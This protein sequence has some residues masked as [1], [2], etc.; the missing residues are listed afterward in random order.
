MSVYGGQAAFALSLDAFGTP[1]S[2]RSAGGVYYLGVGSLQLKLNHA[3]EAAFIAALDEN[4]PAFIGD[5]VQKLLALDIAGLTGGGSA[6]LSV[7][8]I[9]SGLGVTDDGRITLALDTGAALIEIGFPYPSGGVLAGAAVTVRTGD[10]AL[11]EVTLD[12]PVLSDCTS[13]TAESGAPLYAPADADAYVDI[14]EF[15]A[16]LS[17]IRATVTASGF[18]LTLTEDLVLTVPGTTYLVSDDMAA[19]SSTP[20]YDEY[21]EP[22]TAPVTRTVTI[23]A[24]S[25]ATPGVIRI[26]PQGEIGKSGWFVS[27]FADLTVTRTEEV[28]GVDRIIQ[29]RT[30][31]QRISAAL[32]DEAGVKVIYADYDGM[33][34]R[35]RFDEALGTLAYVRDILGITGTILDDIPEDCYDAS[36]D[37]SVFDDMSVAGLESLRAT[38]TDLL[39]RAEAVFNV[40]FGY[41][42]DESAGL[43]GYTGA[44]EALGSITQAADLNELMD[45]V[46]A[47]TDALAENGL[48]SDAA[49]GD[50]IAT[51]Q[52]V[53][54]TIGS[55]QLSFA[56]DTLSVALPADTG[57]ADIALSHADGYLSALSV[58]GLSAGGVT[59]NGALALSTQNV[60][61]TPPDNA[62]TFD[63]TD[64]TEE[65][66]YYSDFSSINSLFEDLINTANLKS[67]F[68]G[69]ENN[70]EK[71]T[72]RMSLPNMG[73][74]VNVDISF[75]VKVV[76]LQNEN[77][78]W[79]PLVHVQLEVPGIW[80]IVT[81]TKARNTSLYFYDDHFLFTSTRTEGVFNKRTY[82]E[83][84]HATTEDLLKKTSAGTLDINNLMKYVY[85]MLPLGSTIQDAVNKAIEKGITQDFSSTN[86]ILNYYGYRNGNYQLGIDLKEIT[87]IQDVNELNVS[88]NTK[89]YQ[90]KNYLNNVQLD[91][92]FLNGAFYAIK[93][94]LNGFM[95][96]PEIT[97]NPQHPQYAAVRQYTYN[98]Y[99]DGKSHT[100]DISTL[101]AMVMSQ[102]AALGNAGTIDSPAEKQIK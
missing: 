28:I 15:S 25:D 67:F 84:V 93:M 30:L 71:G 97:T 88:L 78:E 31:T 87:R 29:Q 18:E 42:A 5:F 16:Y 98:S 35:M 52:S 46:T 100:E 22:V 74:I 59:V 37:T 48:G 44:L 27:V 21:G 83:F 6:A 17:A 65:R 61:V 90:N 34:I 43:T 7:D 19:G 1:V 47:F 24:H 33:K 55:L 70:A 69:G 36:L 11:V 73:D 13:L 101:A 60:S 26:V 95:V 3:D 64:S 4:L 66:A 51:V 82:T 53:L 14:M 45:I 54:Q 72:I 94:A 12:A 41:E 50:V 39:V 79:K 86:E 91:V 85:F 20:V 92:S 68:I 81:V 9:V 77:K 89:A 56:D 32:V 80:A 40:L 57:T 76:L 102:S 75:S 63:T 10:G 99:A 96:D 8:D 38:I 58:T 23:A 2:V 49:S 62:A